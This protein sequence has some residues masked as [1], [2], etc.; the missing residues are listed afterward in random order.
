MYGPS[1]AEWMFF[2]KLAV[3][4]LLLIGIALGMGISWVLS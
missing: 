4:I 3:A 1:E 2:V